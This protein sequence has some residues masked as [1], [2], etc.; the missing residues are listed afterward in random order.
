MN[1]LVIIS[2]L[3]SAALSNAKALELRDFKSQNNAPISHW[4]TTTAK[5]TNKYSQDCRHK[6][7]VSAI[8]GN[9]RAIYS[10]D[11]YCDGGNA[12]GIV[13]NISTMQLVYIIDD[14]VLYTPKE[15]RKIKQTK[16]I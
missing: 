9:L 5:Q 15:F 16:G 8:H 14:T 1:L 3:L 11:D 10:N 12:F 13:F 2:I 4:L 7:F 6:D